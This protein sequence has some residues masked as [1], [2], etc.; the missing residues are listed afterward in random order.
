[1]VVSEEESVED[2]IMLK[3]ISY[4]AIP[5]A[6]EKAERY[7]LLN[8]PTHAESICRDVLAVDAD[9]E[10]AQ[11]NL[12]LALT[13]QF[14]KG[15]PECFNQARDIARNLK[16]AYEQLY[17]MGII[18]ERGGQARLLQEGPGSRAAA[19]ECIQQAMELYEQAEKVR[20]PDNDDAILRWNSCVRLCARF[21]LHLETP[22]PF[23]PVLAERQAEDRIAMRR[24]RDS[25]PRGKKGVGPF[26]PRA[27]RALRH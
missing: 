2:T 1:M 20:P 6:L 23:E 12:L 25:N 14:R 8:E 21:G 18:W 16:G 10:Q 26:F 3:P 5:L 9:N 7:R 27:A 13:D 15:P 22:Q 4:D 24:E 17:Y 19:Y 11:V